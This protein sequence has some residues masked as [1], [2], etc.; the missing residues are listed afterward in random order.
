M[1]HGIKLKQLTASR[2]EGT[3]K[4]PLSAHYQWR[5]AA[6]DN[7]LYSSWGKTTTRVVFMFASVCVSK[8][9]SGAP[10]T[11]MEGNKKQCA[12]ETFECEECGKVFSWKSNLYR[13]KEI[14]SSERH[15]CVMC[16]KVFRVRRALAL[17]VRKQRC[18]SQ[19]LVFQRTPQP[20]LLKCKECGRNFSR[21]ESLATH[22]AEHSTGAANACYV[23]GKH[24][25]SKHALKQHQVTH[26]GARNYACSLC[27]RTYTQQG[28]LNTHFKVAH[29]AI[30]ESECVDDDTIPDKK[31]RYR[32][33]GGIRNHKCEE[34]GR[35]F[36]RRTI[37]ENH[38]ATH[39]N[40]RQFECEECG[41]TYKRKDVLATHSLT[42]LKKR[43][44]T[45]ADCGK[46]YWDKGSLRQH[47][48]T[49]F[50]P[51]FKCEE[52]GKAFRLKWRLEEHLRSHRGVKECVCEQCGEAFVLKGCLLSHIR[53]AHDNKKKH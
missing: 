14:H 29:T 52:C 19:P 30:T 39:S 32:S 12:E 10:L 31:N 9:P 49:H 15:P 38:Y 34:C 25:S 53:Q 24:F 42:H 2:G 13:H 6:T 23:C 46:Q 26:T 50:P 16:G 11:A 5:E 37:L 48:V 41:K 40:Q 21:P 20:R 27:W 8:R 1:T 22:T 28:D 36:T 3:Y 17:H 18:T 51:A 47:V 43:A 7:G 44:F 4:Q 33:T 45:C 35:S